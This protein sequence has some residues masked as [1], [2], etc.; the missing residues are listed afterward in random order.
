MGVLAFDLVP[1][2]IGRHDGVYSEG[3]TDAEAGEREVFFERGGADDII[4]LQQS[5]LVK[6]HGPQRIG[7]RPS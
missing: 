7:Q 1:L 3:M 4:P 5:D 6:R 2:E